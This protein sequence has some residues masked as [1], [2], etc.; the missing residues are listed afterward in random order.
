MGVLYLVVSVISAIC[1]LTTIIKS[2]QKPPHNKSPPS[3]S[4]ISFTFSSVSNAFCLSLLIFIT[5]FNFISVWGLIVLC[6][7]SLQLLLYYFL[8][9]FTIRKIYKHLQIVL[10]KLH[11]I[12]KCKQNDTLKTKNKGRLP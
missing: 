2:D 4:Y 8:H 12:Y 9:Y 10:L 1:E 5:S 6:T 11:N 3:L 7:P